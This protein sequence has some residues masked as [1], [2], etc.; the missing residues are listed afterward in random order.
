MKRTLLL[1]AILAATTACGVESRSEILIPTMPGAIPGV[2]VEPVTAP[3]S[4]PG[5]Q[6]QQP[7]H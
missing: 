5:A 6:S 4:E 1:L 3:T 7:V 2:Q